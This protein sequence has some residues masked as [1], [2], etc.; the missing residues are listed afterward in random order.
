MPTSCPF[1]QPDEEGFGIV[2]ILVSMFLLALLAIAFL[3]LLITSLTTGVRNTTIA[4][5][6]QLVEQEL[7]LARNE[8]K[9]CSAATTFGAAVTPISTD[10][11]GVSYKP[12]RLV[13]PCSTLLTAY[14]TTVK[15][16]VTVSMIGSS[17]APISATTLLYLGKP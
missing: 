2:E 7:E 5:A 9:T 12:T 3:P 16:T 4:T 1:P 15:I 10:A 17:V 13:D 11:R 14:P 8:E 6:T